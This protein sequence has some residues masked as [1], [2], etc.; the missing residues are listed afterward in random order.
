MCMEQN[1]HNSIIIMFKRKTI[2][3]NFTLIKNK[4]SLELINMIKFAY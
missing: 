2:E 1:H 4:K 3:L